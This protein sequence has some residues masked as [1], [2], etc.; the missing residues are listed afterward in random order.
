[1]GLSS[2]V[3][4]NAVLALH[5]AYVFFVA[6]GFIVIPL[7]GWLHWRWTRSFRYRALHT[8]AIGV[9][10]LEQLGQ[11]TCP[12]TLWEYRLRGGAG[13]PHAFVP[14]LVHD[15]M[16]YHWPSWV[17]TGLYVGLVVL[18]IAFWWLFPVTRE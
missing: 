11:V 8:A 4:A 7:G 2:D 3:L 15:F 9:V 12:L 18:V 13:R 10:A 14:R 1:M 17:F 6:S 16:F 5:V